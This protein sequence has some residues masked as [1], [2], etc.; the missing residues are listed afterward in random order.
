[1]ENRKC[2]VCG[3]RK[4]KTLVCRVG[5]CVDN[6]DSLVSRLSRRVCVCVRV[7]VC[8]QYDINPLTRKKL[9]L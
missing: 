2:A 8:A 5:A 7:C 1:M 6:V 9:P 3:L 4:K